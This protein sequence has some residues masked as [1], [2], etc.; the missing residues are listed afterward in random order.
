MHETV[1][2]YV[3]EELLLSVNHEKENHGAE[4]LK[5]CSQQAMEETGS[6]NFL[7]QM[8]L[9]CWYLFAN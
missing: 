9:I 8:N 3:G 1:G 6:P 7:H 5:F 4:R 2:T